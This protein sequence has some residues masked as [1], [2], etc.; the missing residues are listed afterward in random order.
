M[1]CKDALTIIL[2]QQYKPAREAMSSQGNCKDLCKVTC[3]HVH[4][5]MVKVTHI[6][7]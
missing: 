7:K 4:S 3:V 5:I 2:A 1:P 6:Y